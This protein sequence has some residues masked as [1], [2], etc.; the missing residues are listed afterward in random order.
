MTTRHPRRAKDI[1]KIV[2]GNDSDCDL[3]TSD[4][5]A[6][7]DSGNLVNDLKIDDG[8]ATS[9]SDSED[10]EKSS[11][12]PPAAPRPGSTARRDPEAYSW[13]KKAFEASSDIEFTGC[14]GEPPEDV[15]TKTP[16]SYFKDFVTDEML[17]HMAAETNRY[18]IEKNGRSIDTSAAELEQVLGMYFQM[19]LAAMPC[20]RS[21]WEAETCYPA[22][23]GIMSRDRFEKLLTLLHFRDNNRV[24]EEDKQDRI[25]KLRP[26]LSALRERFLMVTPEECHAV[27]EVIVPFKGHS[28]LKV[29]MPAKPNKWG[30]KMWARAGNSGFLYDFDVYSGAAD[31]SKVSNLGVTGDIVMNL[32]STLPGDVNHKLFADNFFTSVPLIEALLERGIHYIGTVRANRVKQCVMDEKELKRGGRGSFDH[33]V[34][35]RTNCVMVKWLDNRVVNLLSSYVGT[36]PVQT[37]VRWD[38]KSRSHIT[39]RVPAI[40]NMYNQFMGGVDLTDMMS[41]LYKYSYRSRRWYL[42]LFW[43]TVTVA[44]VNAWIL[45]R[46]HQRQ[47]GNSKPQL[48]KKF[49]G[50]V[51]NAL[52]AIPGRGPGRPSQDSVPPAQKRKLVSLPPSTVDRRRGEGIHLPI[53]SDAR[54]RCKLCKGQDHFSHIMC[55]RCEVHLCLNKARNCFA[56]FHAK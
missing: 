46:R 35:Q 5:E 22:V 34:E 21:Y 39:V 30:F 9:E 36:D 31:K 55:E 52:T 41:S 4:D 56:Q 47:L 32:A 16:Y 33:R 51:A 42:Y 44:L 29:Y 45:H 40:V 15:N 23:A 12:S 25:W 28:H 48:L 1:F 19:G 6:E 11:D 10:P 26:W 20:V 13:R 49:Q 14:V 24:S 38:R 53:Y 8:A 27:D 43:H 50:M 2:D 37:A 7:P 18:S 17:E 3:L 54:Q